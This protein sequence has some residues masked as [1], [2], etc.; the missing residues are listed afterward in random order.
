[1]ETNPSSIHED[2]G[3]ILGLSQWVGDPVL[4]WLWCRPA[5]TAPILPLAWEP[6]YVVGMALKKNEKKK[7]NKTISSEIDQVKYTHTHTRIC[8][9]T[10][11]TSESIHRKN[12][13]H[14]L[15]P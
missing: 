9:H 13:S 4:L 10:P 6:P 8:I 3:L 7:Q 15:Q 1:M 5:A 11:Y 2:V 12:R 14:S